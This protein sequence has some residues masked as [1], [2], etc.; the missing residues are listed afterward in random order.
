[1]PRD[2]AVTQLCAPSGD[3]GALMGAVRPD[4]VAT[5]CDEGERYRCQSGAVVGCG[6]NATLGSCVDGCVVE[7]QAI[8][9]DGV[10]REA[11]FAILCS[12]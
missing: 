5:A 9:D 8:N 11:A 10:S 7:G 1:M 4:S 2:R 3:A 6:V 12:R